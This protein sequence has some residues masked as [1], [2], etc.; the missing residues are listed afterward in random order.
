MKFCLLGPKDIML[1]TLWV[2]LGGIHKSEGLCPQHRTQIYMIS[3][4]R[5]RHQAFCGRR[6]A[7]LA[8]PWRL[9]GAL[10]P[11][12]VTSKPRFRTPQP[13]YLI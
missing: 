5:R 12:H 3:G 7:M 9:L 4:T 11:S 13:K 10:T 2:R 8:N 1:A 6:E